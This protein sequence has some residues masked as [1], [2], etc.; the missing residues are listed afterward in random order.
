[1]ADFTYSRVPVVKEDLMNIRTSKEGEVGK[2][3]TY[4]RRP[5][6]VDLPSTCFR[7]DIYA[8]SQYRAL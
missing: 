6:R 4:R 7:T 1:M 5:S 8:L 3:I 2:E